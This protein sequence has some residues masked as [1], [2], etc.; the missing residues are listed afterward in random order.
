MKEIRAVE[1]FEAMKKNLKG[2]SKFN[3]P[4]I[5]FESDNG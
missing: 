5:N 1:H 2:K 4:I 3:P